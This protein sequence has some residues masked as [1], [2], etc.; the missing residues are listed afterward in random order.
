MK[1][2]KVGILGISI[3]LLGIAF[4]TNNMIAMSGCAIGVV[5]SIVGYFV[6]D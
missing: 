6:K 5:V 4:S 1:G 2:I 3:G